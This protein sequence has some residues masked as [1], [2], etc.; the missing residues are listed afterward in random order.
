MPYRFVLWIPVGRLLLLR[1]Q[2]LVSS[3]SLFGWSWCLLRWI[4]GEGYLADLFMESGG[5]ADHFLFEIRVS[6]LIQVLFLAI[7]GI[8]LWW[9]GGRDVVFFLC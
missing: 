5:Q 7:Y 2:K 6:A 9:T 1:D 4:E 3:A 8:F